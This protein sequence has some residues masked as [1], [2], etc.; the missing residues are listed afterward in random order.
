MEIEYERTIEDLVELNLYSIE[1]STVQQKARKSQNY[2]IVTLASI[3]VILAV[4]WLSLLQDMNGVMYLVVGIY[5]IYI[6]WYNNSSRYKRRKVTEILEEQN[7]EKPNA[8]LCKRTM[9]IKDDGFYE[10]S[11]FE[12][13]KIFWRSIREIVQTEKYLYL[14]ET[15][16]IA[17][18]VPRRAFPDEDSF[19]AFDKAA[20]DFY[21][22]ALIEKL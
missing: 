12:E 8:N 16:G 9:T 19:K 22:R 4:I 2:G 15:K 14:F 13:S 7:E 6:L 5:M 21:H 3:F 1:N 20:R 11:D 17:I 10:K 18:I